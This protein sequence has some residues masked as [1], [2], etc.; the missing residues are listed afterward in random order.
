MNDSDT[1][2]DCSLSN[3][4]TKTNER[5]TQGR[6][7]FFQFSHEETLALRGEVSGQLGRV[8]KAPGVTPTS[9]GIRASGAKN[10]EVTHGPN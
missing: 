5:Y 1:R 7:L 10:P 4:G 8:P 9:M 2:R 3:G 6:G